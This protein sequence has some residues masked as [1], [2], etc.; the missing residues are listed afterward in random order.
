LDLLIKNRTPVADGD[1]AR[2]Q[3]VQTRLPAPRGLVFIP[4]LIGG[5]CA[6]QLGAFRWLL[7]DNLDIFTF[8]Y[9]GHGRSSGKF[10]MSASVRDTCRMLALAAHQAADAGRPLY[11]IAACYA[12]LPMLYGTLAAR[13]PF[14]KIALVNPLTAL[15]PGF[16]LRSLYR[17]CKAGFD[18]DRPF[19][20]LKQSIDNY[21]EGLFPG[22][23]RGVSGFGA[24]SRKRTRLGKVV[25][26]WLSSNLCLNFALPNT[27]ALCV[28][29]RQDPIMNLG[30][31]ALKK[32]NLDRIGR[33]CSPVTFRAVDS[34]HFLSDPQ[35]RG[36]TRQAIRSFFRTG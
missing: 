18:L 11:G 23:A 20:S 15:F 1:D 24:L 26:E 25:T 19:G 9:T 27:P 35:S 5:G 34:D 21:L 22:I 16:F 28:Y 29:S 3:W 10:S 32:A 12:T 2:L 4:P 31:G 6:Q 30:G 14:R 13:E 36:A 8:N 17:S 33:I 7:K